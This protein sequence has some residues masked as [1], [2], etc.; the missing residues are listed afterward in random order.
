MKTNPAP[1]E[2][3]K[4]KR[5]HPGFVDA[6]EKPLAV[7]DEIIVSQ[8]RVAR[9]AVITRFTPSRVY[10]V[11]LHA[12]DYMSDN[13]FK[14]EAFS[15]LHNYYFKGENARSFRMV[16]KV[17]DP[18]IRTVPTA[19]TSAEDPVGEIKGRLEAL[20]VSKEL[21]EQEEV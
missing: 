6:L 7:G 8:D 5:N 12:P 9:H 4:P 1:I 17:D 21:M 10:W 18:Q 2:L 14:W 15:Q 16:L 11:V 19:G 3:T 20:R 13:V